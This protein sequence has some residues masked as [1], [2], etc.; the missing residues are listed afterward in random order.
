MMPTLALPGEITPGQF[1]PISRDF[2]VLTTSQVF[3]M[4]STG[5]PSVMQITSGTSA[6][7]ASR[8]PSAANG[9]GTKITETFAPVS[10]TASST[11]LKTGHPSWIVPP[12]PG[13]TPPTTFVP[14]SA[15]AFAWKVPS[16]P[17]IPCT[18]SR[19]F[20]STKTAITYHLSRLRQPDL[21]L[22]SSFRQ[23]Q[24]SGR[25]PSES[26]GPLQRSCL[27]AAEQ[28]VA[29]HSASSPPQPLQSPAHPHAECR[30]RC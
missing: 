28:S 17:V 6:A 24:T 12:L 29:A 25:I 19:V 27:P 9:G 26:C 23:P 2:D 21:Q 18:I 4:S 3:T 8:I 7:V 10:F 13:V 11:V 22:P 14:Y 15:Q 30:R 1:G 5:M 20:L 16:R